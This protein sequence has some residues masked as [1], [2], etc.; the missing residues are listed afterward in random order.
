[1]QG[2][3]PEVTVS[4]TMMI[5]GEDYGMVPDLGVAVLENAK[6]NGV[7][8][9]LVNAMTMEF[10]GMSPD[11][12]D[13]V[14]NA[15]I[16]TLRQ[17]QAIWPEKPEAELKKMLGVTPMIGRN[18]N[19]K[20]FETRHGTKLVDWANAN[21]IGHLSFW[22][23][24][25][26]NGD[27][28]DGTLSPICSGTTQGPQEFTQI[29]QG[30]RPTNPGPTTTTTRD[31]TA[32]TTTSTSTTTTPPSTECTQEGISGIK[33]ETYFWNCVNEGGQLVKY[34]YQCPAGL[35][36]DPAILACNRPESIGC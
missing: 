36:F 25:R 4:Y 5:Q 12:G 24:G 28:P 34:E 14:I 20:V 13:S 3:R 27:C 31:P 33:C 21:N 30:F 7:R 10:P 15:S 17:M 11:W 2:E 32:T 35:V 6:A 8:V 23:I 16:A 19:G 26:D 22:S 9:D 1:M 29:F 18:F